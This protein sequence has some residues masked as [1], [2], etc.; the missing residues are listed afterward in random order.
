MPRDHRVERADRLGSDGRE[1]SLTAIGAVSP[2]GGDL[3]EPVAQATMRIV[4]VFWS[5]DS[6]L[7][8]QRHFPAINWLTSY[9]LYADSV[10][11][12]LNENVSEHWTALRARA[13]ALL[14]QE[15]ELQEIVQLVG[16]DALSAEDRMV[17]EVT[18]SIREDYIQQN[19]FDV[20]DS[21]STYDKQYKMLALVMSFY[22]AG[23]QALAQGVEL[24]A[25]IALPVRERIA[26]AKEVPEDRVDAAYAQ[27]AQELEQ[28]LTDL[29]G[30]G[31][32]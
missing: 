9:S 12:W 11:A 22:D 4:K 3:S 2:A 20:T 8:Y 13:M 30:K 28:Q 23:L 27:I 21:Y 14:Q 29:L 15:A 19:A 6:N 26:R 25:I 7:A 10:G 24:D 32:A 18:R 16:V 17:L 31:A 1:G 5:L